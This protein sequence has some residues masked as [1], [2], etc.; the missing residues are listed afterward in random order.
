MEDQTQSNEDEILPSLPPL[1]LD[2]PVIACFKKDVDLTLLLEN[3]KLTP[4]E[5]VKKMQRV[6]RAVQEMRQA[7]LA[8]RQD[9]SPQ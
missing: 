2:D 7:G 9:N 8:I 3:L 5:R 6:I 1:V 4:D